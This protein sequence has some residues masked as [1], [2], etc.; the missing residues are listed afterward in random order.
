MVLVDSSVWVDFFRGRQ[1][2][3]V[4]T[5]DELLQEEL[6][7]T[8]R[9]IKAEII[10][11][12]NTRKEFDLLKDYFSVLPL[13]DDPLEFW[14]QIVDWRFTLKKK[15]V[16]GIDIADLMIAVLAREYECPLLTRDRHFRLMKPVMGLELVS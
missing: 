9:L 10:P 14:E 12:A 7:C 1:T 3:E 5:L 13:L 16:D 2:P 15:G 8:C 4:E 6:V 11:G